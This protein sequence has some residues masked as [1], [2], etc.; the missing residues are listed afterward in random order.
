MDTQRSKLEKYILHNKIGD[1]YS[2][3]NQS[4]KE[5]MVDKV[6]GGGK[7]MTGG[8]RGGGAPSCSIKTKTNDGI[9]SWT[10]QKYNGNQRTLSK[11]LQGG[12]VSLPL[13]YF[14]KDT[15]RYMESVKGTKM[16][17]TNPSLVRPGMSAMLSGG[18]NGSKKIKNIFNL[19]DLFKMY[20]GMVTDLKLSK[21]KQY[22][23]LRNYNDNVKQFLEEVHNMN[24]GG[25]KVIT[26]KTVNEA[27]KIFKSI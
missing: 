21:N 25:G 13:E 20:G 9:F 27:L 3:T 8:G 26:K 18:K 11:E 15:G 14:G 2:N 7:L 17:D 6:M 19:S 16:S 4:T 22:E 24:G 10:T 12:R 1:S 23:L 5:Y